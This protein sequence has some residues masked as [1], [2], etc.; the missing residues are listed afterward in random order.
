LESG[1]SAPATATAVITKE[2]VFAAALAEDTRAALLGGETQV[3]K[4]HGAARIDN[5]R[6]DLTK[7]G[8]VTFAHRGEFEL[9]QPLSVEC[10]VW[11][12]QVERM[13]VVVSCGHWNHAGWFL[14]KLGNAWRWHVGGVDCDGGQ[15]ATGRWIH[16]AGTY[17]GRTLRLF[18][19]GAQV[20]EKA[21]Q[22]NAAIWPGA[23]H[24]GQYSGAPGPDFQV[25]GRLQGVKLYHRPLAERET[26]EAAKTRPR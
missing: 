10:W 26:V 2:P 8:H 24:V 18:Q 22:V 19:D 3:G 11:L 13:P 25:H 14:Q 7:G 4:T 6:L 21:G 1:P 17:D 20:A 12:D 15:P 23:L 16:L 9:G 5:G